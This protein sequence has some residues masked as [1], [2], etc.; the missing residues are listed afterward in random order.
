MHDIALNLVR[1]KMHR[2]NNKLFPHHTFGNI[3]CLISDKLHIITRFVCSFATRARAKK[4]TIS[5]KCVCARVF[6]H[7]RNIN[8]ESVDANF[9]WGQFITCLRW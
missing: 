2:V 9:E 5:I 6:Y 4:Y 3:V 8:N 1:I 7:T